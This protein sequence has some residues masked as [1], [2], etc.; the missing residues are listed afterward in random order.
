MSTGKVITLALTSGVVLIALAG[1][2]IPLSAVLSDKWGPRKERMPV[3]TRVLGFGI[4]FVSI[5]LGIVLA[6]VIAPSG[7]TWGMLGAVLLAGGIGLIVFFAIASRIE[8]DQPT[9]QTGEP[10]QR[11]T[12]SGH[13]DIV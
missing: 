2:A 8:K 12:G 5:G 4:V 3:S 7:G 6:P 9:E 1:I 11:P 10:P 13:V